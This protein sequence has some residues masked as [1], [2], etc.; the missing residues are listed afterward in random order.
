MP[1]EQSLA[2]RQKKARERGS[3][4]DTTRTSQPADCNT[5][6]TCLAVLTGPPYSGFRIKAG[7][8]CMTSGRLLFSNGYLPDPIQEAASL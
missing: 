1:L 2:E 3:H 5:V 8:T 7:V 4:E 6:E